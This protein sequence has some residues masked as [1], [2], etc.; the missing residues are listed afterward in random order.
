VTCKKFQTDE[1]SC[2]AFKIILNK[3]DPAEFVLHLSTI[4]GHSAQICNVIGKKVV[5][6][7]AFEL[8]RYFQAYFDGYLYSLYPLGYEVCRYFYYLFNIL[9]LQKIKI[10]IY[11]IEQ[12]QIETFEADPPDGY[13]IDYVSNILLVYFN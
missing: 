12:R 8:S 13:Y 3:L 11:S 1:Y 4:D 7:D 2:S 6:G 10:V 5:V 9:L